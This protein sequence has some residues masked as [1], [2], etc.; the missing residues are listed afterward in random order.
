MNE[1]VATNSA[2]Y[3]CFDDLWELHT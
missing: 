1:N 2:V 3:Q